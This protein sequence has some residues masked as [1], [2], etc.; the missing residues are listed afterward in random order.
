MKQLILLAFL[1]LS[2][3]TFGQTKD[4][5]DFKNG[6]FKITDPI[7]GNSIV[8][9]KGSKQIEYGEDSELKIEFK[10]KWLDECTYK[11]QVKKILENPNNVLLP[12][13]MVLTVEIIETTEN[14][15]RQISTSNLYEGVV[16]SEM[17][18]IE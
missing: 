1:T 17:V 5:R 18:R 6:K 16:E 10:V 9:R 15:Y 8:E 3:A 7:A 14:S 12:S 13:D 4:C 2:T 11:L